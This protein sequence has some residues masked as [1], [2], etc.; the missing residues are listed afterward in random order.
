[1]IATLSE[2]SFIEMIYS[3]AIYGADRCADFSSIVTRL[4][5]ARKALS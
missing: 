2:S 1:M 4:Q 3:L 5:R